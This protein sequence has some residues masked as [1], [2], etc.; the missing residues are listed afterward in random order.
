MYFIIHCLNKHASAL[1]FYTKERENYTI[2]E[3]ISDL[4]HD[5]IVQHLVVGVHVWFVNV[6]NLA[7][8]FTVALHLSV[9]K[10]I[11]IMLIYY[12]CILTTY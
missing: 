2:N 8:F 7:P 5:T 10:I 9:N 3:I 1:C 12:V 11:D 4:R 6:Y